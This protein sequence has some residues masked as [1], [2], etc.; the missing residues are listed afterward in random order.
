MLTNLS[1]EKAFHLISKFEYQKILDYV[2][3][4]F[5][6]Y[7]IDAEYFPKETEELKK[8]VEEAELNDIELVTRK[9]R[10]VGTDKLKIFIQKFQDF[11]L[12]KGVE[13]LDQTKVDDIVVEKQ[14]VVGVKTSEGKI[15]KG[16]KVLLAPGRVNARWLQKL[17][18]TYDIKYIYDKVEV[19][20]RVEF[21][22]SVMK[23]QA[24]TLYET[25]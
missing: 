25:V 16:K 21:P 9:A 19:G 1:H 7:G 11:L 3:T 15:I 4:I 5:N 20:V 17:A 2:D 6:K 8:L 24:E 22:S 10:H 23:R 12:S 14:R 13:I 18:D